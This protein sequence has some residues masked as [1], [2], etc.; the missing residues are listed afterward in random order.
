MD[1]LLLISSLAILVI[2]LLSLH[3][4]LRRT[5][6]RPPGPKGLP[7][8]GNI[9]QIYNS[10]PHI[11]L[12]ELSYK[13]GPLIYL[14]FCRLPVVVISSADAAKKALKHNNV[15]FAGCPY[16]SASLRLTY[17]NSNIAT[18]SYSDYW[19]K[20]RKMVVH[21]LF[22]PHKLRSYRPIRHDEISSMISRISSKADLSEAINLGD[23]MSSFNCNVVCR[24]AF[25]KKLDS[26]SWTKLERLFS[27]LWRVIFETFLADCVMFGFINKLLGSAK[28]VDKIF[29]EMDSFYQQLIDEHLHPNRPDSM[30]N[31]I[32]HRLIQLRE[33][34]SSEVQ[35]DWNHVKAILM[36]V[37]IAGTDT[38]G[39]SLTWVMT[40]LMKNLNAMEKVQEEI[41]SVV[42]EKRLVHEDDIENLPYLK[43]VVKETLR[44]YPIVPLV[45][46]ETIKACIIDGY[47]IREKT[48][49]WV[50]IWAIGRDP[51][52]WENAD[53]FIPERFL[54]TSI[55]FRGQEFGFIPFG[56][57]RRVCVG[58]SLAVANMEV[59]LANLLYSFDWETP[60]EREIDTKA[61]TGFLLHKKNPLYLQP[62]LH[63]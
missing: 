19:R 30:T 1:M 2:F 22:A 49:V 44:L 62:I 26:R 28:R 17:N 20:M 12:T 33:D 55:D 3:K 23:I 25:G 24:V 58:A 47:E 35:I 50:N 53:E 7:F 14:K 31:D 46:K 57:G 18:S 40:A 13:Y 32:L 37:L 48:F 56:S 4:S 10:K 38:T 11:W 5:P 36:D 34:H 54:N 39:A 60:P 59:A 41:R 21:H 45:P 51:E 29:E 15:T 52:Y 9:H 43:A 61:S 6:R 16:T 63:V 42:R 8:I 27:R